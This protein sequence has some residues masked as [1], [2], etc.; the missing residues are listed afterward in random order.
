MQE[1]SKGEFEFEFGWLLVKT[2]SHCR[3][4]NKMVNTLQRAVAMRYYMPP[5]FQMT[6]CVVMTNHVVH[7]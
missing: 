1:E 3:K 7:Y 6:I 5:L 2:N 4:R